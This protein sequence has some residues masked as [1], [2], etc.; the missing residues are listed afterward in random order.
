MKQFVGYMLRK[1]KIIYDRCDVIGMCSI[2]FIARHLPI[3][4]D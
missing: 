4:S 2:D 3:N 1:Y